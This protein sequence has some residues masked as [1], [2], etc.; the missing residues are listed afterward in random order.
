MCV[1]SVEPRGHSLQA[2]DVTWQL[3]QYLLALLCC[4]LADIS[5]IKSDLPP[6]RFPFNLLFGVHCSI[7]SRE[8]IEFSRLKLRATNINHSQPDALLEIECSKSW[9]VKNC[10]WLLISTRAATW[11]SMPG[12]ITI[13]AT[14]RSSLDVNW[15]RRISLDSRTSQID[16]CKWS[17]IDWSRE[18]AKNWRWA[19]SCN[20][21]SFLNIHEQFQMSLPIIHRSDWSLISIHHSRFISKLCAFDDFLPIETASGTIGD[22]NCFLP[23]CVIWVLEK[24]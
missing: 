18:R 12:G 19:L 15:M 21:S 5:T 20:L 23:G 8:H 7:N 4:P 11:N 1:S 3:S 13:N 2:F 14:W 17:A 16:E 22:L 24:K 9:K 6:S 10:V